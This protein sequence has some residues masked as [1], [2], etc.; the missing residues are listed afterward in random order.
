[1]STILIF[2]PSIL[3]TE[4]TN[5]INHEYCKH[6][7]AKLN[8]KEMQIDID[9]LGNRQVSKAQGNANQS[10]AAGFKLDLIFES[11]VIC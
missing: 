3:K 7:I 8:A 5:E 4:A 9:L 1:M 6:K 10:L 2:L 11:L